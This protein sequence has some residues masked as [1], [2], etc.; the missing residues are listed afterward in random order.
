MSASLN[1]RHDASRHLSESLSDRWRELCARYLPIV[2]RDSIWRYSRLKSFRDPEQGWK[3]HVSATVLTANKVLETIGPFL[4]RR[5]TLFKGPATL[6]ELD[7]L[8]CG[9]YY[10]YT[11]VGK[12]FTIYPETTAEA[13]AIAE[14][15]H[16]LTARF[17]APAVPFDLR[18]RP[19]S[20]VYYRYGAFKYRE[21]ENEDGTYTLAIRDPEGKLVPDSRESWVGKPEWVS[22]PFLAGRPQDETDDSQSAESPLK[23]TI[24]VFRALT[25]RGK[26]GVYQAIDL[27]AQHPRLCILKEGRKDGEPGWDG[28][29]GYWR[30]RNEEQVL[31]SLRALNIKVPG[32]YSSFEVEGNF[33][34]ATEFIQGL[35]LH[36]LLKKRRRRLPVNRALQYG[37]QLSEQLSRI[38]SAGWV[39]RDCK[40]SNLIVTKEGFLRPIDF[41]GACPLNQPDPMPWGTP[42]FVPPEHGKP[43][44]GQSRA[45]EDLYSL[46]VIIYLL[47]SGSTPS[48]PKPTPLEK[49]RRNVPAAARETISELL[50]HDASSRPGAHLVAQRLKALL[51]PA[52]VAAAA[53]S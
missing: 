26:G 4:R 30:V 3:L 1:P 32:V 29:D 48:L 36:S 8:N 39:W 52:D 44:R 24:R 27:S 14:K 47:L 38:H 18:L 43:F 35:S 23:T 25:Q 28:R 21:I 22:D 11:Q 33:Y 16:E 45:P 7:K 53:D 6:L 10:G 51:P 5:T 40:P 49:L 31:S 17:S 2:Q 34:L 46:G 13:V 20:C 37:L 42:T 9:S 15:L 50:E 12:C 19:D 41:E